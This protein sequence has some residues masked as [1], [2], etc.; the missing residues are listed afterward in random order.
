M[1]LAHSAG[2]IFIR[3]FQ[4]VAPLIVVQMKENGLTVDGH[5]GYAETGNDIICAAVSVLAQNFV[6]SVEALTEDEMEYRI[7]NGHMDIKW[8]SL[9]EQGRLLADSFFIGV[10]SVANTYGDKFVRII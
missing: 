8:E 6:N 3:N 2:G 1:P 4:E 5:A 7:W 10:C 9:S